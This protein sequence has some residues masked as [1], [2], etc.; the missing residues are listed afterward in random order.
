MKIGVLS[1]THLS[2]PNRSLEYIFD[3]LFADADLVL[4]AGD[5]SSGQVLAWLE[6]RGVQ[7][8]C[9][10]MDDYAVADSIPQTRR[11]QVEKLTIGLT[12]G[13]G[14]KKNL[15]ERI[16]EKFSPE[17]PDIIVYGHT[18]VPFWGNVQGVMM[19]NPGS[20]AFVGNGNYGTVGLIEIVN[21]V[22][23]AGFF[24]VRL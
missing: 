20:A 10:N 14:S 1:D 17:T 21:N 5:I 16:I 22:P 3:E 11:L 15:E 9:G 4:H 7:A 2:A 19:F 8:V 23:N 24:E 12:H 6:A 13:W 18:H